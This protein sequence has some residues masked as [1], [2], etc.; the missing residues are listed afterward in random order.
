MPRDGQ[1]VAPACASKELRNLDSRNLT[2]GDD[3]ETLT[4]AFQMVDHRAPHAHVDQRSGSVPISFTQVC[5]TMCAN[6]LQPNPGPGKARAPCK[7]VIL[8]SENPAT[9]ITQVSL[10]IDSRTQLC[11][12]D[13]SDNDSANGIECSAAHTILMRHA[14]SGEKIDRIVAALESGCTPCATGGCSVKQSIV[15]R[16]L[17]E[18]CG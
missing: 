8:L 7:L 9:S 17:D 16:T 10:S 11:G 1:N 18:E 15:W 3:T 13:K 6:T 5:A 12:T 14:T 4:E 2:P